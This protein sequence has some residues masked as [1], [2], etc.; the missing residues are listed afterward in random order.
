MATPWHH[1]A[2]SAKKFGGV[3]EDYWKL[4][5]WFDASKGY[6]AQPAHRA[7]RHHTAGVIEAESVFGP[8]IRTSAGRDIPTRLLA[9]QHI[10]E[11]LGR[12]PTVEDWL[13][14]L[15]LEGWMLSGQRVPIEREVS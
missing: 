6:Y 9:E 10:V 3:P 2:S 1:A 12:I 4:H 14:N 11:D 8:A 7:L 15:P 13:R 5:E